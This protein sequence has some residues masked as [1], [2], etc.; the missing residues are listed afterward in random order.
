MLFF[1]SVLKFTIQ[2]L[3]QM[4]IL[5]LLFLALWKMSLGFWWK[6]HQICRLLLL[7]KAKFTILTLSINEHSEGDFPTSVSSFSILKLSS[8]RS[9]LLQWYG[10]EIHH[11]FSSFLIALILHVLLTLN[12]F[13]TYIFFIGKRY[14]AL[15][16]KIWYKFYSNWQLLFP[17]DLSAHFQLLKNKFG[18][19]KISGLLSR[20]VQSYTVDIPITKISASS[21]L[22]T[23][24]KVSL[25]HCHGSA[26][27]SKPLHLDYCSLSPSLLSVL[28]GMR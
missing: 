10:I 22:M 19:A 18:I 11:D 1:C 13:H 25:F 7:T 23:I 9:C 21:C 4:W 5:T 24:S 28:G 2:C 8:L 16:R 26:A 15:F 3:S 12:S 20:I 6:L 17:I 14:L 27:L